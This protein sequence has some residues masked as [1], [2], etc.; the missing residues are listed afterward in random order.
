MRIQELAEQA[1]RFVD[2]VEAAPRASRR[3]VEVQ[4]GMHVLRERKE[5]SFESMLY[6]PTFCLIL[7]GSKRTSLGGKTYTCRTG[8]CLV[9]SHDV[10]VSSRVIDAPYLA[11]LLRLDVDLLRSLADEVT[12]AGLDTEEARAMTVQKADAAFVDALGRALALTSSPQAK[13]I[14][15]LIVKEIHYRLL[16]AP[17]GAMLRRMALHDPH[18]TAV[19]RAITHLRGDLRASIHVAELA[20]QVGMSASSFHRHFKAVTSSTPL[21]FQKDLRLHEAR[22]LITRLGVAVSTAAYDVGYESPSQFSREYARKFGTAPSR[23]TTRD[24]ARRPREAQGRG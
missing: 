12:A 3:M 14:G 4:K 24:T 16:M 7:Q 21:Q 6:E 15:P 5:T 13:V 8:D 23:D 22:R 10:A 19:A 2:D 9:I 18:A 20:R 17:F 1:A 11:L